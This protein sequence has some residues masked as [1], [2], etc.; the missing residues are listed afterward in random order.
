[1]WVALKLAQ[2]KLNH[3]TIILRVVGPGIEMLTVTYCSKILKLENYLFN[4]YSN[5]SNHGKTIHSTARANIAA[6]IHIVFEHLCKMQY[7]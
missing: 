6:E 5:K 7:E 1:M 4:A 2:L 3:P